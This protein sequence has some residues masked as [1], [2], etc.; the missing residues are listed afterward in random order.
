MVKRFYGN[1]VN[2]PNTNV[3]E[4]KSNINDNLLCLMNRSIFYRSN[5]KVVILTIDRSIVEVLKTPLN[6]ERYHKSA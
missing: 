2:W 1:N 5:G 6:H 4:L 3:C